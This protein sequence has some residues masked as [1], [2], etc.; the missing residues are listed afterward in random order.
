MM[1]LTSRPSPLW[2]RMS[3]WV[4]ATR[5]ESEREPRSPIMTQAARGRPSLITS[6]TTP[7]YVYES[8]VITIE[9]SRSATHS[10]ERVL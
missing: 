2:N 1:I 8:T 9:A 5:D 4:S 3:V 10:L 7:M 6:A